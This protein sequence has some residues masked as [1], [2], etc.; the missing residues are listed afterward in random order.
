MLWGGVFLTACGT[1]SSYTQSIN[2]TRM[3]KK[4]LNAYAEC[5]SGTSE[6]N[7]EIQINNNFRTTNMI[8]RDLKIKCFDY[9]IDSDGSMLILDVGIKLFDSANSEIGSFKAISKLSGMFVTDIE[10]NRITAARIFGYIKKNYI[11]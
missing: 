8:G 11:K 3:E 9:K 10:L 7:L 2:E 6:N 1:M 4:Y 5:G